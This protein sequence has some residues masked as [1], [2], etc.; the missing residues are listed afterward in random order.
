MSQIKVP[1]KKIEDMHSMSHSDPSLGQ[2]ARRLAMKALQELKNAGSQKTLQYADTLSLA[3]MVGAI[4][5]KG[6][7]LANQICEAV[8]R[9]NGGMDQADTATQGLYLYTKIRIYIRECKPAKALELVPQ[10]DRVWRGCGKSTRYYAWALSDLTKFYHH[11]GASEDNFVIAAKLYYRIMG[12]LA[13]TG[14]SGSFLYKNCYDSLSLLPIGD[15]ISKQEARELMFGFPIPKEFADFMLQA[16]KSVLRALRFLPLVFVG[17]IAV[18][19]GSW[20]LLGFWK[21]TLVGLLFGGGGVLATL[22]VIGKSAGKVFKSCYKARLKEWQKRLDIPDRK[23]KTLIAEM[24]P[25]MQ[26]FWP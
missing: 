8:L 11:S 7:N 16:N 2:E 17:G 14:E 19:F 23:M 5:S 26:E 9:D 12:I 1:V 13:E 4:D 22:S 10:A 20:Y 3:A 6:F 25:G 21:G 24:C 18:L 15:E